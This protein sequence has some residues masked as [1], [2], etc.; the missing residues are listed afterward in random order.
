MQDRRVGN[1]RR[2]T[3]SPARPEPAETGS[4]PVVGTLRTL[5]RRERSSGRSASRRAWGREGVIVLFSAST[6]LPA[7]AIEIFCAIPTRIK[8]TATRNPYTTQKKL[9]ATW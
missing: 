1:N 6:H 3:I 8:Y 5:M 2:R 4:F 9:K 7:R